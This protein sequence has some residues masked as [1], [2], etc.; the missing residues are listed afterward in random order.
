MSY[1]HRSQVNFNWISPLPAA[2]IARAY[3]VGFDGRRL[4][5]ETA[6]IH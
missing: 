3:D 5:N 2:L 6:L 4:I 1:R